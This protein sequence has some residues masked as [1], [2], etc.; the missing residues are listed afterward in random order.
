LIYEVKN[1]VPSFVDLFNIYLRSYLHI[2]YVL[3]L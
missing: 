3:D 2:Y 1:L